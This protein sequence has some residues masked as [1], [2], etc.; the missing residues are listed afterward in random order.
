MLLAEGRPICSAKRHKNEPD[1]TAA[2]CPAQVTRVK[3]KKKLK[4]SGN[5]LSWGVAGWQES[6]SSEFAEAQF[7]HKVLRERGCIWLALH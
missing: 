4:K 1:A 6:Q 3:K 7:S 5:W 2:V